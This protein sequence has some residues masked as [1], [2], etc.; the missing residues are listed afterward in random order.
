MTLWY[1][2]SPINQQI[3]AGDPSG[4]IG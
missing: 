1:W 2:I 4:S 3:S